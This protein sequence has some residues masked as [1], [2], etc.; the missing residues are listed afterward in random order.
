MNLANKIST[1]RIVLVP[2]FV[3]AIAYS[4][5]RIALAIFTVCILSDAFDG[6]IARKKGER[7]RLGTLL[8]PIADKLLMMTAFI[9]LSVVKAVPSSLRFPL[10][11][12]IIAISRDVLIILGCL[13]I[14]LL[15]GAVDIKPTGLGKSTTF[16][17]MASIIAILIQFDYS[18]IIWNIT[19]ILT[20]FS[21]L[22]YLRIASRML[23][24]AAT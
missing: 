6:Y 24:E 9:S 22:D 11:V 17:Q 16:F 7:T 1:T 12:P 3:A 15:K 10:Y 19:V 4:Q 5:F 20:V 13:V 21:G 18:N 23:N 8:D 14:Y 2:F